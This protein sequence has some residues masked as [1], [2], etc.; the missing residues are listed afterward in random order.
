MS[1]L[2]CGTGPGSITCELAKA[3]APGNVIGIDIDPWMINR[4]RDAAEQMELS[5]LRL[6]IAD[7]E[8]LPFPDA[9]FDAVWCSST[10]QFLQ[11]PLK[12][13]EEVFRVLKPGGVFGVR[14]RNYECDYFGNP[15]PMLRRGRRIHYQLQL[16][17][18]GIDLRFGRMQRSVLVA[19][20]FEN[21]ITRASFEDHGDKVG[22][23]WAA[24][25]YSQFYRSERRRSEIAKRGYAT[26]AEMDAMVLAWDA[27][28]SDPRS[29]Y[30]IAR[31]ESVGWKPT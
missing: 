22:A 30:S 13:V 24:D 17:A 8:H 7:I 27:W 26:V 4:A 31:I 25:F 28:A 1:L 9:S 21:L 19:A 18:D 10:L 5:N 16:R 15:S 12:G 2:D 14:D 3:L 11:K 29:C 6:K 23:R 20:G